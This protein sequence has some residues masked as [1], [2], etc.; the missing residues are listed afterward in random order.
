MDFKGIPLTPPKEQVKEELPL[1][2]Q[3]LR[4]LA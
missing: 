4:E 2:A 1:L 3:E